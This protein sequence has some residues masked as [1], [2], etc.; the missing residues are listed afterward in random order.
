MR[1]VVA[2][3]SWGVGEA[4]FSSAA[5]KGG[6]GP[7]PHGGY[8]VRQCAIVELADGRQVA[9]AMT[10]RPADG[11]SGLAAGAEMLSSLALWLRQVLEG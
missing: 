3:Q 11:E 2:G 6:W 4:G 1:S 8:L 7:D 10:A 5:F 9:L